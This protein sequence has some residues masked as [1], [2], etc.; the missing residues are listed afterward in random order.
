MSNLH[1]IE[2]LLDSALELSAGIVSEIKK[3]APDLDVLSDSFNK[4]GL[5]LDDL[6]K[7]TV[8]L[9]SIAESDRELF[10]PKL[11]KLNELD[12]NIREHL[13]QAN[14]DVIGEREKNKHERKASH[15]YADKTNKSQL[16]NGRLEG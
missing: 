3:E 8:F 11:V 15:S 10:S 16:I 14:G 9:D 13:K 4:R 1:T 5:I 2:G 7:E 12:A 6:K